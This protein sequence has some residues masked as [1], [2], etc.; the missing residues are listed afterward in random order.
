M[1]IFAEQKPLL[2][3]IFVGVPKVIGTLNA[4]QPMEREWRTSIFKEE[5]DE[6]LFLAETNLSGDKQAD[7]KHHGGPEKAVFS[8]PSEHYHYW[9]QEL[10]PFEI[11]PGGMGENFSTFGMLESDVA[12]GDVFEIGE[13][14][15]QVSQPR[16]PCWKPARRFRTKEFAILSQNTG[17]TGWYYRVL[18]E[19]FVQAGQSLKLVARYTPE[20]TIE[21]CNQVMHVD[22]YNFE[23]AALLAEVSELA[24]NWR[25]TLSKR[26][27]N[28]EVEDIFNRVYGSN[29]G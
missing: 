3:K 12:I 1:N 15:I 29:L 5:T 18:Q 6:R 8:Y 22:R 28:R 19:G 10:S 14:V 9:Q 16:Q 7:L 21:Q 24:I 25:T 27:E 13:T 23:K 20:W 26:V 2:E 4:E 17:R 11:Q